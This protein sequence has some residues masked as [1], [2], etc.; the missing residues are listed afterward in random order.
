MAYAIPV[1]LT[2]LNS[3]LTLLDKHLVDDDWK[4]SRYPVVC[5]HE[6][7]G[8]VVSIGNQVKGLKIGDRVR[9]LVYPIKV[10]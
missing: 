3:M 4:V 8:N 7:I 1:Q 5:G 10:I 6:G 2:N 9:D